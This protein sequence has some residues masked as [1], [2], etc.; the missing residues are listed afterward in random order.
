MCD[1][2]IRNKRNNKNY[3]IKNQLVALFKSE[4]TLSKDEIVDKM[5][6]SEEAILIH[7]RNL[8]RKDVLGLTEDNKLYINE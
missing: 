7:L 4:K 5:E 3:N 6:A 8:L 2:C 1:V